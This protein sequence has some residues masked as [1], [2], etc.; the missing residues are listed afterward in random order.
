MGWYPI[1]QIDTIMAIEIP[2]KVRDVHRF[3]GLVNY[4]RYMWLNHAHKPA[5]LTRLCSSKINFKWNDMEQ[6]TFMDMK[7]IVGQAVFLSYPNF[8]EEF[9]SSHRC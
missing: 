8:I 3:V 7:N 1:F 4:Y 2:Y 9:K 5:P 6:K